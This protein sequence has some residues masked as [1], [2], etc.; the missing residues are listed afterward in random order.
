MILGCIDIS[1]PNFSLPEL[2]NT[3]TTLHS[4]HLVCKLSYVFGVVLSRAPQETKY[5]LCI[6]ISASMKM[7]KYSRR[8]SVG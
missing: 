6:F 7:K 5:L 2:I 3:S 8:Q 1:V 4:V